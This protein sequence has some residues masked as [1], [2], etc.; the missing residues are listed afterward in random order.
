MSEATATRPIREIGGVPVT[1]RLRG[2]VSNPWARPRGLAVWTWLYILWSILPIG[3]A[4]LMAFNSG[5]ST[6]AFQG[7]SLY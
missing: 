6:V 1:A 7:F 3:F 4:I 2:W 5:R